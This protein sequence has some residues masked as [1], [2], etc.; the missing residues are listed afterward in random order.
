M[1]TTTITIELYQ[2]ISAVDRYRCIMQP[3]RPHFSP[4]AAMFISFLMMVTSVLLTV[5]KFVTAQVSL[6][7][8]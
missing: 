1:V 3:E 7:I 2:L 5:P 6:S 4:R 8:L